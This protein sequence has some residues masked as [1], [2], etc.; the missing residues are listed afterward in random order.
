MSIKIR[1]S[2]R[3]CGSDRKVD[4]DGRVYEAIDGTKRVGC[5]RIDDTGEG[6]TPY[7]SWVA[8]THQRHGIGTKLYEA[9]ARGSCR[10]F[11]QPLSSD[12]DL[13][14]GSR[15]FWEK[16]LRKGRARCLFTNDAKQCVHFELACPAPKSLAG[17]RR[18]R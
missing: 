8:P 12:K 11:R 13:S 18:K 14:D 7:W 3:D 16:Q 10:S 2:K 15:G 5:I 4:A 9:A 17:A 6:V 1:S